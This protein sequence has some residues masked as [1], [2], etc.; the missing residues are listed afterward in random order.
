MR[1]KQIGELSRC[2]RCFGQIK[3]ANHN[4]EGEKERNDG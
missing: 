2:S 3:W 4:D 1:H